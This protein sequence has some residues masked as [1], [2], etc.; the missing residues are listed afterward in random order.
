MVS[1]DVWLKTGGVE[2]AAFPS[3]PPLTTV[4]NAHKFHMAMRASASADKMRSTNQSRA[5]FGREPYA[6]RDKN[7]RRYAFREE[8]MA[9]RMGL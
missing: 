3:V 6:K 9:V 7:K 2:V 4:S 8:G 5:G 1:S